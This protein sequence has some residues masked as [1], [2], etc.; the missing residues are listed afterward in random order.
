MLQ[1][2]RDEVLAYMRQK[3]DGFHTSPSSPSYTH[4][5]N[6][7]TSLLRSH[8]P[9]QYYH[10]NQAVQDA[11]EIVD[12]CCV[13]GKKRGCGGGTRGRK[14]VGWNETQGRISSIISQKYF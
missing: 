2:I 11:K 13:E 5:L 7:L 8:Y 10:G 1:N 3:Y 14:D 6:E 4:I 12:E 9:Q